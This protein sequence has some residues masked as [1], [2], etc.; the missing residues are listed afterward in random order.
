MII[1]DLKIISVSRKKFMPH[2]KA[3]MQSDLFYL[4]FKALLIGLVRKKWFYAETDKE[5]GRRGNAKIRAM[6]DNEFLKLRPA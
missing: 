4:F 2:K 3:P 6:Q 1:S 5:T